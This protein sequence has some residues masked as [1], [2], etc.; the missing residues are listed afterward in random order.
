[1]SKVWLIG[2]GGMARD[3]MKVLEALD[4]DYITIGRGETSSEACKNFT[5]KK[6]VIGGLKAFLDTNPECPDYAIVATPVSELYSC[7][8][9]LLEYGVKN[10]LVEKPA[11]T[12][13][14]ELVLLADLNQNIGANI[15]LAYNRR[16]YSSVI[17]AKKM[18]EADGGPTSCH[19]EFTEWSHV[20]E[21]LDKP[22]EIFQHW[23]LGNSTHVVDLAFYLIGKPEQLAAFTTGA[24]KWHQSGSAFCGAGVTESKVPFSYHANWAAPGR[25]SVE[26]LTVQ[27]RYI[28]KPMEELSIIKLGTVKEEK[29]QIDNHLDLEYKPGLYLETKTFLE[30]D[31]STHCTLKD[32]VSLVDAYYKMANYH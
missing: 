16:F 20:I 27:H 30:N 31:L 14:K 28:F 15:V 3:Y 2:A 23:F 26:V 13:K 25:W 4:A 17:H 10:I 9:Q 8:V 11:A 12:T 24:L 6:I 21:K 7:S 32:Q 5:T 19:F 22:A 18:I 29:I 1:M